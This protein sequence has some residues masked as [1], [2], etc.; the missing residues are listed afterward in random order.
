MNQFPNEV[1]AAIPGYTVRQ[2]ATEAD[3][4]VFPP[5]TRQRVTSTNRI[6]DAPYRYICQIAIRT[7][8]RTFVG[9]GTLVGPRTVLTA[10]HNLF[11]PLTGARLPVAS[12]TITPARDGSAAPAFGASRPS[13]LLPSPGYDHRRHQNTQRDFAIIQLRDALGNRA[14][15]W[16]QR[17]RPA[18]DELGTSLSSSLPQNPGVLRVNL[19]GYP[20]DK[21]GVTQW[22]SYNRTIRLR[23]GLLSYE[24][25]T[26]AGHSGSPV[27][28]RRHQSM[29][30]RVLVGIHIGFDPVTRAS[31]RAVAITA[32]ILRF[33][34][35]NT[36]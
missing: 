31:N 4:L 28:V 14:G 5:D 3:H 23:D 24:N 2:H 1:M 11:S 17:P 30:G 22:R 7:G 25:D 15:W 16:G 34:A 26:E 29:G 19:S 33:I 10:A 13:R 8:G 9:T 12:M 6:T 21:G 18:F 20:V 36:V 32:D 27:W 35:T